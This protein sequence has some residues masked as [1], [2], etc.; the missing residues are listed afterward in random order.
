VVG[1]GSAL[2][3]GQFGSLKMTEVVVKGQLTSAERVKLVCQDFQKL[4]EDL[5]FNC[6]PLIEDLTKKASFHVA[7]APH[8]VKVLGDHVEKVKPSAKLPG[9]YLID[10]IMKNLNGDYLRYFKDVIPVIFCRVF[11]VCVSVRIINGPTLHSDCI[12]T[13]VYNPMRISQ[14]DSRRPPTFL[15][16]L[17][18]LLCMLLAERCMLVCKL[19]WSL[20]KMAG[21]DFVYLLDHLAWYI[22][23]HWEKPNVKND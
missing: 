19:V 12:H 4:L 9:L 5:T 11:E 2:A 7:Y 8:I 21:K 14:S 18:K 23:R 3:T 20:W 6:R 1:S 16:A 17:D 15:H 13:Y 22:V 10:S